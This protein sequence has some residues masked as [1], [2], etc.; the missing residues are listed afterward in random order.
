MG[1]STKVDNR[2]KDILILGEGPTQGLRHT[3]SAEKA[4]SINFTMTRKKFCL[5]LL[6]GQIVIYLLTL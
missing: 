5:S 2:E 1:L 4:H 3:L 6:M